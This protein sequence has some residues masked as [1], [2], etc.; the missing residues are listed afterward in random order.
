MKTALI[1]VLCLVLYG[2][3]VLL[4]ARFLKSRL[5]EDVYP[6]VSRD[7]EKTQKHEQTNERD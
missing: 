2:L 3:F 5:G 4:L 7:H 6:Y 1:V